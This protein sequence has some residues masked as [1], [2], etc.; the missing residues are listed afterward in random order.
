MTI[1][2]MLESGCEFYGRV[3]IETYD[4]SGNCETLYKGKADKMPLFPKWGE[5]EVKCIYSNYHHIDGSM[6]V[7]ELGEE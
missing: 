5:R 3:E 6:L 4:C 7:I 1:N 2:D